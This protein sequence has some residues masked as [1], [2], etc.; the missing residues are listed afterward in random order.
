MFRSC[1]RFVMSDHSGMGKSLY[2]KRLAD[3]LKRGLENSTDVIHVTVPLHGP[4]VT[5]DTVLNLF[6]GHAK[7]PTCYIYH[8]DIAPNVSNCSMTNSMHAL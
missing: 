4:V 7:N 8:I 2:I 5:P 1:V 3:S 6:K